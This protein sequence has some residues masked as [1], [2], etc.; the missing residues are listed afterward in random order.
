MG[1]SHIGN[2]LFREKVFEV[3]YLMNC[4]VYLYLVETYNLYTY[5]SS[6][7][8]GQ[9]DISFQSYFLVFTEFELWLAFS[10]DTVYIV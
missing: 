8:C 6:N 1:Y 2:L 10:W 5:I 9:K 3:S 4:A 7:Y